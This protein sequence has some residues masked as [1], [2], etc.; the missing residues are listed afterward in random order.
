VYR[1][2]VETFDSMAEPDNAMRIYEQT[3]ETLDISKIFAAVNTKPRRKREPKKGE[4]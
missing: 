4:Q 1:V 2:I 3:V